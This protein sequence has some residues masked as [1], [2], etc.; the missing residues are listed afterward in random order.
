MKA[1]ASLNEIDEKFF[2]EQTKICENFLNDFL[3]RCKNDK[4]AEMKQ[5]AREA[6]VSLYE[7]VEFEDLPLDV[8]HV[9]SEQILKTTKKLKKEYEKVSDLAEKCANDIV[10]NMFEDN[11]VGPFNAQTLIVGN[12]LIKKKPQKQEVFPDFSTLTYHGAYRIL[13]Y[14]QLFNPYCFTYPMHY[15]IPNGFIANGYHSTEEIFQAVGTSRLGINDLDQISET[16]EYCFRDFV[17]DIYVPYLYSF[18]TNDMKDEI[19]I[20]SS[21]STQITTST[22]TKESEEL[23]TTSFLSSFPSKRQKSTNLENV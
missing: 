10:E 22:S 16:T 12:S 20:P 4:T 18:W 19:S 23:E 17:D 13:S 21:S 6:A 7:A 11:G 1:K 15:N 14:Y 5:K 8:P 9:A 3:K 2:E